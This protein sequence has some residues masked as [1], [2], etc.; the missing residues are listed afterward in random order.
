MGCRIRRTHRHVT[1]AKSAKKDTRRPS[2]VS[3]PFPGSNPRTENDQLTHLTT[4]RQNWQSDRTFLCGRRE[5]PITDWLGG[6]PY[7]QTL[8][9]RSTTLQAEI[10]MALPCKRWGCEHCGIVRAADLSRRIVEARP[11]KFITL[12]VSSQHWDT[13]REAYD[14]TRR[15]LPKWSNKVRKTTG[16]F[17]FVRILEVTK[18]GYP[19]YHLLARCPYIPQK[20][21]SE[22]WAGLTGSPIVDVRAIREGQNSVNYVCK[23]LRKQLYCSFTNRRVSWSRNFFPKLPKEPRLDWQLTHKEHRTDSPAKVIRDEW[24]CPMLFRV[25]PY[26]VTRDAL[27]DAH[28]RLIT[29]TT[30]E[31]APPF[32]ERPNLEFRP[33]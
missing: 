21:L 12:T 11:T 15:R 33:V 32:E 23:Y 24:G 14:E 28:L 20:L 10:I 2:R 30:Q 27:T 8:I 6:C 25:G 7:A 13:P 16:S 17:E 18:A 4:G 31:F 26:A 3:F 1:T 19:H 29:P 9:A 5:Q 22:M